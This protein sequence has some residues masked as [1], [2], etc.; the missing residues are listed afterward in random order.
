MADNLWG[1]LTGIDNGPQPPVAILRE[2]ATILSTATKGL[3][4]AV[5]TPTN[6]SGR[7]GY[8]FALRATALNDY[9]VELLAIRH[10]EILYPVQVLALRTG[11]AASTNQWVTCADDTVF[12]QVL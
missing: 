12:K 2:Q 4:T 1:D 10:T 3:V 11:L 9:T 6:P 7:I 5:V 8:S